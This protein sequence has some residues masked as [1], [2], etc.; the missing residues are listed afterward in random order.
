MVPV[1]SRSPPSV[2][3]C[4]GRARRK[5]CRGSVS[6]P[7]RTPGRAPGGRIRPRRRRWRRAAGT[8]PFVPA[9]PVPAELPAGHR[10][11]GREKSRGAPA[12][13]FPPDGTP[14]RAG[15]TTPPAPPA[16][17][18]GSGDPAV[19]PGSPRPCRVAG[20]SPVARQREVER[21]AR[22]AVSAGRNPGARRGG[23]ISPRAGGDAAQPV[24]PFVLTTPVL[25]R[26][27]GGPEER[28]ECRSPTRLR[29]GRTPGRAPGGRLSRGRRRWRR[30]AGPSHSSRW[31]RSPPG[32][33][34]PGRATRSRSAPASRPGRTPQRAPGGR[35]SR[36]RR[37]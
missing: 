11:P 4:P 19:R 14:E 2:T 15:R 25:R 37:R 6:P 7:G 36:G 12:T 27:A 5:A 10:W 34:W 24:L 23:R 28:V 1:P 33:R 13:R 35:L 8:L 21:R 30:A 26:V 3:G 17:T 16:V 18:P 29:S 22:D 31:A 20:R 32:R 9:A